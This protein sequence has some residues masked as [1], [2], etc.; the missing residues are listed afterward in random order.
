[1]TG[2]QRS[3]V[4]PRNISPECAEPAKQNGNVARLDGDSATLLLDRPAAL[5]HQPGHESAYS[6]R[7]RLI[8]SPFD[9]FAVI[10]IRSGN[11][12]GDNRRVAGDLGPRSLERDI[13]CMARVRPSRHRRSKGPVNEG[14]DRG[15]RPKAGGEVQEFRAGSN[16]ALFYLLIDRDV[17]P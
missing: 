9:D 1:T 11:R 5:V 13:G 10:P 12:Q 6:V 3:D 14:L 4:G 7:K 2:F 16:K 15:R 17:G 8:D